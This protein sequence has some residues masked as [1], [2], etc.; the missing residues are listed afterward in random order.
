MAVRGRYPATSSTCRALPIV[1]LS[2]LLLAPYMNIVRTVQETLSEF[3]GPAMPANAVPGA[4][5]GT[6]S[7]TELSGC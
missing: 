1:P 3:N 2:F 4:R 5:S 7:G 6:A